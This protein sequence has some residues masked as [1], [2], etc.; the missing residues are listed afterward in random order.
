MAST[1]P[2]LLFI[3][4]LIIWLAV[5]L[6]FKNGPVDLFVSYSK[7]VAVRADTE[8]STYTIT[9]ADIKEKKLYCKLACLHSGFFPAVWK[10]CKPGEEDEMKMKFHMEFL[11][12]TYGNV[13]EIVAACNSQKTAPCME[14]Q[15][16]NSC[17]SW[18]WIIIGTVV[19]ALILIAVVVFVIK[20]G[21]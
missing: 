3:P 18:T 20:S 7:P 11:R 6:E 15:D 13:L 1:Y 9:P 21:R 2:S 14:M 5:S 17:A 16:D 8:Q 10:D 4:T 12:A 19:G